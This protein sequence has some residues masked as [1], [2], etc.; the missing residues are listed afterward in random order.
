MNRYPKYLEEYRERIQ[1]SRVK[2]RGDTSLNSSSEPPPT[3]SPPPYEEQMLEIQKEIYQLRD[4][5]V[6]PR[7]WSRGVRNYSRT[8]ASDTIEMRMRYWVPSRTAGPMY[9]GYFYIDGP[10]QKKETHN[11]LGE[12]HP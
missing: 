7:V 3:S 4:E 5:V 9:Q 2:R 10:P 11:E 8:D 12:I 6:T 1:E